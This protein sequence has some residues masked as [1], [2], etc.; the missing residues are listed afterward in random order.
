MKLSL[1]TTATVRGTLIALLFSLAACAP[2]K[3]T[4]PS[5]QANWPAHQQKQIELTAWDIVGK[6]G[7]RTPQQSNSARFNWLQQEQQFDIRVSN[8]LGQNLATL[9]G[10]PDQVQLDITGEDRHITSNPTIFLEQHLGWSLPV[11]MLSYWI[12]GI[13][14]PAAQASYQLNEQ[15]LLEN[16]HQAGWQVNFSRYQTLDS[17]TLPVKIRL[18]QNSVV[19]TLIIKRWN[20]KPEQLFSSP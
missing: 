6:L 9:V 17:H 5:T 13:P 20:L 19:L 18:Q 10:S 7:I 12:K 15:G 3:Q 14:A 4:P 2:L 16:L 1:I 8:L 11:N